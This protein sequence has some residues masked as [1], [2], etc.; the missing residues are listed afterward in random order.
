MT[1]D[2]TQLGVHLAALAAL[3]MLWRAAPD[4]LQRLALAL[5]MLSMAITAYG[6]GSAIGGFDISWMVRRF[7]SEL[8]HL[9]VLVYVFR[10]FVVDQER[11]CLN[12][13]RHS[14]NS[15]R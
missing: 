5:L 8:E 13:Y 7:A 4:N 14:H 3:V 15:Q 10:L 9:G 11:R 12:S 6:Y 1:W 2:I